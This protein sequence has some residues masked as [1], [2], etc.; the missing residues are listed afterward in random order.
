MGSQIVWELQPSM[1]KS[2]DQIN[3]AKDRAYLLALA[4][5]RLANRADRGVAVLVY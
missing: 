4:E 3:A 2:P 5:G 1:S